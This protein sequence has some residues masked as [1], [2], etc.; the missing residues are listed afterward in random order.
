MGVDSV[1]NSAFW[2]GKKVFV[3][4]HTGF[5]GS[6]LCLWLQSMGA[7]VKGYALEAPTTP[8]IYQSAC[9]EEGM[10]SEI[11]DIRDYQKME[12]SIRAFGPEIV[13]HMA[14]QP[15]VRLSYDIPVDTYATNVMGT[16][17]LLEA[18]RKIGGVKAVVNITSDKCYENKEWV[19]GYRENEPMGGYD[20]Y[21]NSKGCAELV[22]A[23]Y[24]QSYFNADKY[25]EHGCALASVRA[26]NVIGGGD[27]A[28]DRLIPDILKAFEEQ[29]PVLIRS[30]HAIR[31][32]QHVL[33]PLS[34][35]LC[36]AQAL[37]LNGTA[38]AEGWNFGPL[39]DDAQ[40]VQWIVEKM[41]SAWGD[42]ASWVLDDGYHP[43]EAHYLKLDCSKAKTRLNW[44]PVWRLEETLNRIV[45]WHKAWLAGAD[46]RQIT[47]HEIH[48]YMKTQNDKGHY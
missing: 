7:E 46:M 39:D 24:R 9:V 6:W 38:Y 5:K 12:D 18:V 42:D 13:F 28:L 20:P 3:T 41:V 14:A 30:P 27:W 34:G 33:E 19:W 48:D 4:G 11:G 8:S 1:V 15:L 23:A 16:V 31:P 44:T 2:Q 25:Q 47:L 45:A 21:S 36:I 26:G 17:H 22:A 32:W 43:H 35:Y 29:R 37:Y 40:P 10:S